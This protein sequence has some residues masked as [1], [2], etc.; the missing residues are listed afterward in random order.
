MTVEYHKKREGIL[1]C[2]PDGEIRYLTFW[3]RV[4]HFF[5]GKP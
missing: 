4:I 1:R 3:E 2:E 5:G